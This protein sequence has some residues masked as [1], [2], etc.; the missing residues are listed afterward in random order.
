MGSTAR[1]Y[2]AMSSAKVVQLSKQN[3]HIATS[4][5]KANDAVVQLMKKGITVAS[6]NI[7][8]SQ[9]VIELLPSGHCK[10]LTSFVSVIK[11]RGQQRHEVSRAIV[12]GCIVEWQMNNVYH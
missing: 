7:E 9:P 4:F 1:K 8:G 3:M 12:N 6:I 5:Q 2:E 11:Y 10:K